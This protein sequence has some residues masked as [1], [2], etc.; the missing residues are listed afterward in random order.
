METANSGT[1]KL[2][3]RIIAEAQADAET[4]L[5]K[6]REAI[7]AIEAERDKQLNGQKKTLAGQRDAAVKSM[8]DGFGTRAAL[9]GRKSALAKKRA[10]IDEAFS[11]AY[12]ALLALDA[13]ERGRICLGLLQREAEGG[14][15]VAPAAVDRAA[16]QAA[17]ATL[18]EKHLKLSETDAPIDGGFLLL[19]KG[20]QKDC[21]FT[22]LLD[23]VRDEEE[24]AV[25]KLLFD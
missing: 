1:N 25:A 14:E 5:A 23:S 2:A 7:L 20:Y 17:L 13:A 3:A 10:V 24:T 9:D 15:T 16:L 8:I 6:G 18:K 12:D 22:A 21:S 11:R 19:G 4:A